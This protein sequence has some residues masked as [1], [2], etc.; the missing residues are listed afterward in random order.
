MARLAREVKK[1]LTPLDKRR[2]RGGVADIGKI[3]S[4]PIANVVDIKKVPAVFRDQTV[5]QGHL[6]ADLDQA[7]SQ[8]RADETQPSGDENV[9]G[10]KNVRIPRHGRIVGRGTKDFL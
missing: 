6:R 2:H 4:H 7:P 1:K 8:G 3:D 10:G 5:Y 9:G